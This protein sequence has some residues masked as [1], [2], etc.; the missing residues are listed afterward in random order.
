[1]SLDVDT[2]KLIDRIPL[3]FKTFDQL[4]LSLQNIH[5]LIEKASDTIKA[6][7]NLPT[8]ATFATDP[9]FRT[10]AVECE[11]RIKTDDGKQIMGYPDMI[12]Y[13]AER[14]KENDPKNRYSEKL[15]RIVDIYK[16]V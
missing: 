8:E 7:Y 1:M 15:G 13:H 2:G 6:Y 4:V 12:L 5:I 9:F 11:A 10:L 16:R 14:C 3:I